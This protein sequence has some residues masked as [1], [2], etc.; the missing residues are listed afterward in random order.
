[1][2]RG[3]SRTPMFL[4]GPSGPVIVP[5][6]RTAGTSLR[7]RSVFARSS[8]A[9]RLR[10]VACEMTLAEGK[11]L[12]EVHH[13]PA[14]VRGRG[15]RRPAHPPARVGLHNEL[16]HTI[17]TGGRR[18][19][20][21]VQFPIEL[22]GGDVRTAHHLAVVLIDGGGRHRGLRGQHRHDV[23]AGHETRDPIESSVVR[24]CRIGRRVSNPP[25]RGCA[26]KQPDG[27]PNHGLAGFI[28]HVAA[29]RCGLPHPHQQ[30][31]PL[32]IVGR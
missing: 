1:M 8:P 2:P 17:S 29:D 6:T 4:T 30:S 25:A 23:L 9:A 27:I 3:S 5:D 19:A 7:R 12:V 20:G 13:H 11:V 16:A 14:L 15:R 21:A 10:T 18:C 22:A 24:G 31:I 28:P 26:P 32:F